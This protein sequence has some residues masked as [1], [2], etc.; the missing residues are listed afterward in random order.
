MITESNAQIHK[1]CC[2]DNNTWTTDNWNRMIR[3]D[4]PFLT[5]FSAPGRV[6]AWRTP[7]E[8]YNPESLLP[9]QFCDAFGNTQCFK[10]S[11]ST[12]MET[13]AEGPRP[14]LLLLW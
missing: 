7:I 2:H 5:L 1:E 6:D 9:K 12:A 3:S 8:A 4:V 11:T 14:T 10:T 13:L